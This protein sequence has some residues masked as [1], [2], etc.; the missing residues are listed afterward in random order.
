M[1]AV[2]D[3]RHLHAPPRLLTMDSR[4]RQETHMKTSRWLTLAAAIMIT[5]LEAWIFTGASAT[6]VQAADATADVTLTAGSGDGQ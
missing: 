5:V 4:T 6:A 1:I 3:I 2:L